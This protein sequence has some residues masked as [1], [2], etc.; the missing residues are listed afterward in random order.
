M[1][2][3]CDESAAAPVLFSDYR[4]LCHL[5]L[6]PDGSYVRKFIDTRIN[7][8][9]PF[10]TEYVDHDLEQ[11]WHT[12]SLIDPKDCDKSQELKWLSFE[13]CLS[14][15]DLRSSINQS[16]EKFIADA[17]VYTTSKQCRHVLLSIP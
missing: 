16:E 10:L 2:V 1:P 6:R 5:H 9:L 7:V 12:I 14:D 4:T 13:S 3:D 11:D 8:P 17:G 15:T